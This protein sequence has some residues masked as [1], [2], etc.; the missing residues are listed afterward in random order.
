MQDPNIRYFV[1][2]EDMCSKSQV[3]L[4]GRP[5]ENITNNKGRF[6]GK[7]LDLAMCNLSHFVL[8][9]C[10]FKVLLHRK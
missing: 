6:K 2:V 9:Q 3:Y 8:L 4:G 7:M 10:R 5:P 1:D